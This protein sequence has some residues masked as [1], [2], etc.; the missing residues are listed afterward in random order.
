MLTRLEA[1][2]FKNLL[3]FSLDF[4]PVTCIAGPNAVGKSNILDAIHFLSLLSSHTLMEAAL[5]VRGGDP[6]TAEV[7][8]LFWTDGQSRRTSFRL[9]AEMIVDE[10]IK[11]DFGRPA[12]ATSTFLRY[13]IKL[14]YAPPSPDGG[15]LGNLTLLREKL[16]Y[17][18]QGDAHRHLHFEHSA[19]GFR[20]QVVRNRRYGSGYI[21]TGET[22]D[23]QTEISVHQDG[24][25]RGPAQ[26]ALAEAA[27]R[28]IVATSNT[29]S[30]PTI[31]AARREMQS[32]R[33][34]ALEPSAMR[35]PDRFLDE[36]RISVS[37]GHLPAT[38]YRLGGESAANGGSKRDRPVV[39]AQVA[40]RLA[41][42]VPVRAVDIL[43]DDERRLLTLVVT[44][45]SG[46]RLPASSLSDGTLRFLALSVMAADPQLRGVICMEEPENGIHPARMEAM[47]ELLQALAVDPRLEPGPDNPMRQVVVATHSPTFVQLQ[48]KDDLVFALESMVRGEDGKPVGSIQCLPLVDTW[49]AREMERAVGIS[50]IIDYLAS[51]VGSQ[52]NLPGIGRPELAASS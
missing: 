16:D 1:D 6:D 19:K 10:D 22:E 33:L 23:G 25:S 43:R 4:G 26:K 37:G 31:L 14:G 47:V 34:L 15:L 49:R 24:G 32:W 18:T 29:S 7:R 30:T 51:P 45:N 3:G 48:S 2:G 27:P 8:D 17:I 40:S 36:P 11:D 35:R 41:D 52:F 9:A 38:L 46:I 20:G 12:K 5:R 28:T 13:E 39:Y 44:E 50:T 42:L 21:S